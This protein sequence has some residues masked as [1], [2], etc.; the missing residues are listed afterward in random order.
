M[1]MS[2]IDE[3]IKQLT[4]KAK[5]LEQKRIQMHAII[6]CADNGHDFSL[7]EAG[8]DFNRVI[9][10]ELICINCMAYCNI[11]VSAAK[12]DWIFYDG[13]F[14]DKK[15][16]DVYEAEPTAPIEEPVEFADKEDEKSYKVDVSDIIDNAKK[17]SQRK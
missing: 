8:Y 10:I 15:I 5:E 1:K 17:N 7:H 13:P 3:E 12:G 6:E 4:A 11:T 2:D 14:I 9:G 16:K